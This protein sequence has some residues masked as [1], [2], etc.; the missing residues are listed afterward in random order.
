MGFSKTELNGH[1]GHVVVELE[2]HDLFWHTF[3]ID[4]LGVDLKVPVEARQQVVFDAPP[5]IYTF[6]CT[7]RDTPF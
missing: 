6:H 4:E 1:A 3:T 2:N 5:G 7:F